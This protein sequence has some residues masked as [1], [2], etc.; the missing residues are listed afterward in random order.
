MYSMGGFAGAMRVLVRII[1]PGI[2]DCLYPN[3]VSRE[4]SFH[5]HLYEVCF[6]LNMLKIHADLPLFS[7]SGLKLPSHFKL[8]TRASDGRH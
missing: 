7:V 5:C 2:N 6:E 1:E 8:G 4:T 3:H